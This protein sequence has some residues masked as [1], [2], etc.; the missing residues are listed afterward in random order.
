MLIKNV[1]KVISIGDEETNLVFE[2]VEHIG[3][4][5]INSRTIDKILFIS[6]GVIERG[7]NGCIDNSNK[8]FREAVL[9]NVGSFFYDDFADYEELKLYDIGI[10]YYNE[11][12]SGIVYN[13]KQLSGNC[14]YV[15]PYKLSM[16]SD[17]K[18]IMSFNFESVDISKC[19]ANGIPYRNDI[20]ISLCDFDSICTSEMFI[21]NC[22]ISPYVALWPDT[23]IVHVTNVGKFELLPY[24]YEGNG[25]EKFY[26]TNV[27][28][29]FIGSCFRYNMPDDPTLYL[30]GY[31]SGVFL[32]QESDYSKIN[33]SNYIKYSCKIYDI[34]DGTFTGYMLNDIDKW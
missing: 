28:E 9:K 27:N 32:D 24:Q 18:P 17:G 11:D 31:V 16:S 2:N 19:I 3:E 1:K 12:D 4:N 10:M 26:I 33:S 29:L 15:I 21:S 25:I 6:V 30:R 22:S 8:N 13:I 20:A 23:K 34:S 14:K 7:F 5:S